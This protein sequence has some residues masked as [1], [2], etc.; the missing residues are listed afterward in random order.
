MPGMS[1]DSPK[2][3]NRQALTSPVGE[4]AAQNILRVFHQRTRVDSLWHLRTLPDQNGLSP[5]DMTNR[6]E[7]RELINTE[8]VFASAVMLNLLALVEK[9]A[10]TDATVLITGESGCGKEV[11]AQAVHRY[12]RRSTRSWVDVNCAALPENLLESEL[13]GYDKGAFSGADSSKQGLF[14]LAHQGT[15]FLDE[16]GDLDLRMQVKLLRVLDGATYYRVGGLKK[17]SVNVRLVAATNQDLKVAVEQGRFRTDLY[18]RL[19]QIRL[20]VP[21]LRERPDDILPLVEHCLAERNSKLRFTAEAIAKLRGYPWPGNVREL[22]N[23]V[24]RSALLASGPEITVADLPDEFMESSFS[25]NLHTLAT[26]PEM[27]KHA[28]A[29]ALRQSGGHQQRAANALGISRRTLQRKIKSY[30]LTGAQ[31]VSLAR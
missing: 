1:R 2:G 18:H 28:I 4:L 23:V 31:E 21:P 19:S 3:V 14:E 12:S 22:R 11:I 17:V 29:K 16:I 26:L 20:T 6:T 5:A 10:P 24:I 27:E 8:G 30:S 13:F 9:V 25:A 15:L 7:T